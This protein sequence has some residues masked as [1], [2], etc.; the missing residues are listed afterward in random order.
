MY[1]LYH[2]PYSQHA[3]RV[4]SLLVEANLE[5]ELRHVALD[6]GEQHSPEYLAINPNHQVPTLIDGGVKIH[7]S[8]AI[9][10]YLCMKHGL[11]AWYPE[12]LAARAK[13]DQWLDWNQA[14]LSPTV[15]DIVFNS[16]FLGPAGDRSAVE[17]GLARLPELWSNLDSELTDMPFLA[18]VR[19]TI[20]DLSLASN[21]FQLSLANITPVGRNAADWFQRVSELEGFQKSLPPKVPALGK[22]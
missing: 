18:G 16:V 11:A 8:N 13:V 17:R 20:A 7:E 14:R 5:Y 2:F 21:I 6:K 19:P 1:I 4:V 3:R 12:E 22:S 15:V 9:L 10:R